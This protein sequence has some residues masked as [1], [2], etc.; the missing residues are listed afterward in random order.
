[1]EITQDGEG[2][3]GASGVAIHSIREHCDQW[4]KGVSEGPVLTLCQFG[5]SIVT[6]RQR[7]VM[8]EQPGRGRPIRCLR[9]C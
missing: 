4:G 3:S 1:V 6:E 7:N 8:E 5:C 2:R 9:E